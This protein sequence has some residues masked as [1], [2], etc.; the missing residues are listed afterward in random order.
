MKTLGMLSWA[1]LLCLVLVVGCQSSKP[2]SDSHAAVEITG[3]TREAIR[4]TTVAVFAENGY[5]LGTNSP[6]QMVFERPAGSGEKLKYGDWM[7]EG[8][9]ME[10]KVRLQSRTADTYL[11]RADAYIVH[12]PNSPA[13]RSERRIMTLGTGTYQKLLDDVQRRLTGPPDS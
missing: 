13:F 9:L 4:A 11:L 2:G 10:I 12:D 7:N 6:T 1:G 3:H 8:M 5:R